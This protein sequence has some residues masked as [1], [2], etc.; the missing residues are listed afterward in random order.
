MGLMVLPC[1]IGSHQFIAPENDVLHGGANPSIVLSVM[2]CII[3][4]NKTR[5][6]VND[7]HIILMF[8]Y[9]SIYKNRTDSGSSNVNNRHSHLKN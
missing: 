5:N 2:T 8:S 9:D 7:D 1:A 3:S 4:L 6:I